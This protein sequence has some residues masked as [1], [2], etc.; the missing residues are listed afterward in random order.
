MKIVFATNNEYKLEEVKKLLGDKFEIISLK[1]INCKED[2]PETQ[3]TIKGNALQKARYVYQKYNV[4]CF[5]DDTGLI[6]EALNGEPGVYSARYSGA[7]SNSDKN[8]KKVF[9][10]LK[11][12]SNRN[13]YFKTV[14]SLIVNGKEFSFEGIAKGTITTEKKGIS[15]FGYDPIF[16][17]K[18]YNITFA[19]MTLEQK[20]K[21]SHRGKGV[22]KLIEFLNKL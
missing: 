10:K 5:A 22:K 3:A 9:S 11:G 19:E 20:N 17:P 13:A 14:F 6:I 8:I 15:G 21:I 4:N 12:K 2:I 1:D 16:K 7:N 18:D